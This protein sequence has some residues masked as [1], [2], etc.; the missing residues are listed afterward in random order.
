MTDLIQS[1]FF[2]L[3][4]ASQWSVGS[5]GHSILLKKLK[6]QKPGTTAHASNLLEADMPE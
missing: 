4:V 5:V 2:N 1:Q 6:H 3:E